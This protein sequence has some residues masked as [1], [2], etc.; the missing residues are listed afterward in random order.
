MFQS[1]GNPGEVLSRGT[2]EETSPRILTCPAERG[3]LLIELQSCNEQL[4][5][6]NELKNRAGKYCLNHLWG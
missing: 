6:V 3:G 5:L 2:Y 4:L 1:K